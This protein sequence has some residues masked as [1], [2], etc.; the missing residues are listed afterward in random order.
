MGSQDQPQQA[1]R[2]ELLHDRPLWLGGALLGGAGVRVRARADPSARALPAMRRRGR[3][4]TRSSEARKP[5]SP[6]ARRD[7]VLP[8]AAR[9]GEAPRASSPRGVNRSRRWAWPKRGGLV[10]WTAFA[11]RQPLRGGLG[12]ARRDGRLSTPPRASGPAV[13]RLLTSRIE[14]CLAVW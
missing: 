10:S 8:E 14:Q 6:R 2:A 13:G 7:R 5:L 1:H 11:V 9:H 4:A 12:R 3:A